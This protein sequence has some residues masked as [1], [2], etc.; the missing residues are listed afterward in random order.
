MK[1]GLPK[2]GSYELVLPRGRANTR[3]LQTNQ[4]LQIVSPKI[5]RSKDAPNSQTPKR[6]PGSS[7]LLAGR[8]GTSVRGRGSS[9]ELSACPVAMDHRLLDPFDQFSFGQTHKNTANPPLGVEEIVLVKTLDCWGL[10]S[11]MTLG[12]LGKWNP[13]DKGLPKTCQ[14]QQ[15][16]PIDRI[17][18]GCSTCNNTNHQRRLK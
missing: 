1:Q 16:S 5:A 2:Y 10:G 13:P 7:H 3:V 17:P 15:S 14:G 11:T 12:L 6:A 4:D 18:S 8:L 9:H